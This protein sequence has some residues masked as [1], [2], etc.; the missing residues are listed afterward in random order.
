M[1]KDVIGSVLWCRL[2]LRISRSY[3]NMVLLDKQSVD[4]E[5]FITA[6]TSDELF[7]HIDDFLLDEEER[8]RLELYRD[9]CD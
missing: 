1:S 4:R 5:R 3:F 9:H 7:S 6:T 2:A 8:N